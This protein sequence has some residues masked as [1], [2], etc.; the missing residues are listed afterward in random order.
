MP[1]HST[2]IQPNGEIIPDP[3]DG[4]IITGIF[5]FNKGEKIEDEIEGIVDQF[6]GVVDFIV[7]PDSFGYF[8]VET[9]KVCGLMDKNAPYP[10]NSYVKKSHKGMGLAFMFGILNSLAAIHLDI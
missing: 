4:K 7:I 3:L 2:L 9:L 1:T 6:P 10:P 8:W 5:S